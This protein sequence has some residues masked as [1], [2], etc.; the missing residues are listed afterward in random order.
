MNEQ[1]LCSVIVDTSLIVH[2]FSICCIYVMFIANGIK[3][4]CDNIFEASVQ[5]HML[6]LIIPLILLNCIKNLKYL[7]T[8]VAFANILIFIGEH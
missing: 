7:T 3:T 8:L 6:I 4:L 5:M 1:F 2:Q